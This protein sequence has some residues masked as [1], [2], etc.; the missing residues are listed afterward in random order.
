MWAK[1]KDFF[2]RMMELYWEESRTHYVAPPKK[3]VIVAKANCEY[4]DECNDRCKC[5]EF[6]CKVYLAK[7]PDSHAGD[8]RFTYR[9]ELF[10]SLTRLAEI[11]VEQWILEQ[12]QKWRCPECGGVVSFYKYTC[13][14]CGYKQLFE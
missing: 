1:I 7:L 9:H 11:G 4:F 2:G 10:D 5:D 14:K 12:E 6:P 3:V 8:S 13:A